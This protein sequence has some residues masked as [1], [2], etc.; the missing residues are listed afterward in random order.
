MEQDGDTLT[1]TKDWERS[2]E[3]RERFP[4][5]CTA[6]DISKANILKLAERFNVDPGIFLGEGK[7]SANIDRRIS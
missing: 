1:T 2:L 6:G 4:T 7:A 5:S 3:A